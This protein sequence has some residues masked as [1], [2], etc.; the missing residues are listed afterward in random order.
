M[1]PLIIL[2]KNNGK[3][4]KSKGIKRQVIKLIMFLI[5]RLYTKLENHALNLFTS[6][7]KI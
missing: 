1:A 4:S 7:Q 2:K 3:I 5:T 6:I